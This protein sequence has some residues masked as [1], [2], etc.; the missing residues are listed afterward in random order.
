MP[1][2]GPAV[3]PNFSPNVCTHIQEYSVYPFVVAE[4][5]TETT[6]ATCLAHTYNGVAACQFMFSEVPTQTVDT[7]THVAAASNVKAD[8]EKCKVTAA[9]T[10]DQCDVIPGC[11]WNLP[12]AVAPSTKNNVCTHA[13]EKNRDTAAIQRCES[14]AS[15]T[16]TT[17]PVSAGCVWKFYKDPVVVKDT[18]THAQ[19]MS[20]IRTEVDKCQNA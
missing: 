15:Q 10:K 6:D 1:I 5:K 20:T 16:E 3:A 18:C 14:T 2:Q 8:V 17:C 19:T 4:C 11:S 12:A 13:S 9:E 7:C